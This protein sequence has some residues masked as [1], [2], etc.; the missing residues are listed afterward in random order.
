MGRQL[1]AGTNITADRLVWAAK[2]LRARCPDA[3]AELDR[4]KAALDS[5]RIKV[6]AALVAKMEQGGEADA[7]S[8]IPSD[9]QRIP[10]ATVRWDAERAWRATGELIDYI[11]GWQRWLIE[12]DRYQEEVSKAP[13]WTGTLDFTGPN[14]TEATDLLGRARKAAAVLADTGISDPEDFPEGLLQDDIMAW[15]PPRPTN[16]AV[17]V[18]KNYTIP[19]GGR[20]RLSDLKTRLQHLRGKIETSVR[21]LFPVETSAHRG[22]KDAENAPAAKTEQDEGN[23]GAGSPGAQPTAKIDAG[24][25]VTAT[26]EQYMTVQKWSDLGIGIDADGKYLAVSPCP[27]RNGVF[28]REKAVLLVLPGKQWNTLLDLLA[29]S[30]NG[31]EAEKTD[32]MFQF[33]YLKPSEITTADTHELAADAKQ[34]NVLKKSNNS[35][36]QAV[37]DLGRKLRRQVKGPMGKG[38]SAVLSDADEG[39]VSAQFLVRHLIRGPAPP[40]EILKKILGH[41]VWPR[42][43]QCALD[44]GLIECDDSYRVGVRSKG[45]RLGEPYR[46]A[47]WE[48]RPIRDGP[49]V[50]RLARRRE[51]DRRRAVDAMGAGRCRIPKESAAHLYRHLQRIRI[52][53]AIDEPLTQESELAAELIRQGDW[54]LDVDEYGRVHTNITNL[55]K[56]LRKHLSVDG[57]RLVNCDVANSQPLFLGI[58]LMNRAHHI[59]FRFPMSRQHKHDLSAR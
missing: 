45:Y 23:G 5:E 13:E 35:L 7:I 11:E 36:T 27:V 12:F 6:D 59:G 24:K 20:L 1:C 43:R 30:K 14:C 51:A 50:E 52:D 25:E 3:R 17:F 32:V 34:L 38:A 2:R 15:F 53:D 42:V 28:P 57:R 22:V 9:I 19:D 44:I 46:S 31:N 47:K 8:S 10:N 56:T 40:V 16:R 48:W 33:G 29:R 58:L 4:A 37:A 21:T 49:L 39:K 55:K 54:R 18:E 26:D 41:G